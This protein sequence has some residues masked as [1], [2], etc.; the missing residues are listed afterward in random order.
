MAKKSPSNDKKQTVRV[1]MIDIAR[2]AGVSRAAVSYVLN[3]RGEASGIGEKTAKK[4]RKIAAR[5]KFHPN[6]AARQLAGKR[7]GIIGVLANTFLDT[8]LR[9]FG[10]LN[11]MSAARE[12]KILAWQLD[13]HPEQLDEFVDEC[14]SWNLDGLIFIAYKYQSVWSQVASALKRVPRVVSI[15]GNAGI[16]G[17]HTIEI[18]AADGVRQSVE[19]LYRSGRHRIVQIL[20]GLDSQMDQQRYEGFL[21]SHREFYGKAADEDQVCIATKGWNVENYAAYQKL[22]RDLVVDHRADAILAESDFSAPGLIRGLSLM[23]LRVPEDMSLI[24]WGYEAISRGITPGL[25]TVDFDFEQIVER[26]LDLLTGL[27]E[28]PDAAMPASGLVKP[29]LLVRETA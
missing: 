10:C 14:A 16:P 2:K 26:S 15:L 8:E 19:H 20:E 6:R 1:R 23:G 21:A 3:G 25:T 9:I 5:L 13:A 24:G 12:F 4:I 27:I 29:R 18:D 22:A 11:R 28:Q 17:S 7:S